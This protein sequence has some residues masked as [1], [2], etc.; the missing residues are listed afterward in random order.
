MKKTCLW[1]TKAC[2]ACLLSFLIVSLFCHF[3]YNLPSRS[4]VPSQATD[5]G[6]SAHHSAYRGTEGFAHT[7]TDEN[8]YINTY[9]EKKDTVL[10]TH[11]YPT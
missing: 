11:A 6:W 4:E 10:A 3:Y 9:P 5:Y 7:Q 2:F 8:G 1:M